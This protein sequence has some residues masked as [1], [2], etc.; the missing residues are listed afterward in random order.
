MFF[1]L[2]FFVFFLGIFVFF[3]SPGVWQLCPYSC[4]KKLFFQKDSSI[5][6]DKQYYRCIFWTPFW[7]KKNA[8][9]QLPFLMKKMLVAFNVQNPCIST[10]QPPFFWPYDM[11]K[12]LKNTHSCF[13]CEQFARVFSFLWCATFCSSSCFCSLPSKRVRCS[14]HVEVVVKSCKQIWKI[15]EKLRTNEIV[16]KN[17]GKLHEIDAEHICDVIITVAVYASYQSVGVFAKVTCQW[18]NQRRKTCLYDYLHYMP[19]TDCIKLS[20]ANGNPPNKPLENMRLWRAQGV[21]TKMEGPFRVRHNGQ[22]PSSKVNSYK[23]GARSTPK[24]NGTRLKWILLCE[25]EANNLKPVLGQFFAPSL[26]W[27]QPCIWGSNLGQELQDA[28]TWKWGCAWAFLDSVD[29]CEM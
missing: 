16:E 3:I 9:W 24:K 20:S 19:K 18:T 15:N 29:R 17:S 21:E 14:I 10:L 2:C 6:K 28:K 12:W 13:F 26:S 7:K 4:F 8:F 1:I 5:R 25:F 11:D 27:T 22:P 23:L